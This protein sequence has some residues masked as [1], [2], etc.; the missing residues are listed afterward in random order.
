M[1]EK[2]DKK[3]NAGFWNTEIAERRRKRFSKS[4]A[5]LRL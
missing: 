5:R 3:T 1:D 4:S 2:A